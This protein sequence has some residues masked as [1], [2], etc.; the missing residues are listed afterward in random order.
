MTV[1]G[2]EVVIGIETHV[3]LLTRSKMFCRCD[4][5]FGAAPNTHVCPVCLGL[6]GAL[7]VP[8]RHAIELALRIALAVGC[9]IHLT[10]VFARKNYF[11]PDLPKGYQISQYDQPFATGGRVPF[12][13]DG[14]SRAVTLVRIHLEEDAG[15]SMHPEGP[16][17][18][19][20]SVVDLN[21]A[22]VPLVEIVTEPVISA[23]AEASAYLHTLRR[24]VQ[25]LGISD[26]NMEEGSL[27]ADANVSLRKLGAPLGTKT[28]IKNLNSFRFV[29]RALTAEIER[30][31][32]ILDDGGRVVQET[33][34]WDPDAERCVPMRSKEEAHD[35]RYF[36]D[37]DLP[38]LVLERSW[39]DEIRASLPELPWEREARF[40]EA[41]GLPAYDAAVLSDTRPL[42]EY[43]DEV[44][45]AGVSPKLASNWIM[46]EMRRVIRGR[47]TAKEDIPLSSPHLAELLR[48][49]ESGTIS[50]KTAKDVLEE[51]LASGRTAGEIVHARGLTQISDADA[52]REA[53]RDVLAQHPEQLA[54]YRAGQ[55]KLLTF[56]VGQVMKVTR[57]RA[58]PE[59]VHR[60]LRE[61]LSQPA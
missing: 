13:H 25:Y 22:G 44:V 6:P 58:K 46:T 32:S 57:G 43:Y 38:P 4:A 56:F 18:G 55:E 14:A 24:L 19:Q 30:Q 29:E 42:A 59:L 52:L 2:Y 36:P 17:A 48:M 54:G 20:H 45:R 11:Y 23:P 41:Y 53:I 28:E 21:R 33:L 3:Q 61:E 35:Y 7:P 51:M 26:G 5:S 49:V 34:L 39:L 1:R 31:A 10:S 60:L 40:V 15:K 47:G 8:N 12:T 9:D 37:P 50:G 16:D 27:R